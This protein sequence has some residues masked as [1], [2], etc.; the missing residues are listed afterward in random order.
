MTRSNAS[1]F[2]RPH[3]A[4]Q[5]EPG[6]QHQ[7]VGD[8]AAHFEPV[9]L[10]RISP[11]FSSAPFWTILRPVPGAHALNMMHQLV[12]QDAA[13]KHVPL[14]IKAFVQVNG[15]LR[16]IPRK[17]AALVSADAPL[18]LGRLKRLDAWC[19]ERRLAQHDQN[20]KQQIGGN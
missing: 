6:L 10:H 2:A 19:I 15:S 20:A 11:M 4:T 7:V 18:Q 12:H 14:Q 16:R 9:G 1:A 3:A 17:H 8:H 5:R 13:G